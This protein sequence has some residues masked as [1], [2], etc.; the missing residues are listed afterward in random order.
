M[1]VLKKYQK[2]FDYQLTSNQILIMQSLAPKNNSIAKTDYNPGS[3][4]IKHRRK[5]IKSLF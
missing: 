2:I 3:K 5:T 4:Y 1:S